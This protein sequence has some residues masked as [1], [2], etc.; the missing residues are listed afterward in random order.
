MLVRA[1]GAIGAAQYFGWRQAG[2]IA[3]GSL[4]RDVFERRAK[5]FRSKT[6]A[7][8]SKRRRR[9]FNIASCRVVGIIMARS[10]IGWAE[11]ARR[12]SLSWPYFIVIF[13]LS[14]A[15]VQAGWCKLVPRACVC[16]GLRKGN[17]CPHEISSTPGIPS[18]SY[19]H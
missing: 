7:H 8:K 19:L 13:F 18:P 1:I 10:A 9:D 3:S 15:V 16:V 4:Q 17:T 6:I 2:C 12:S 5:P 11:R 14:L